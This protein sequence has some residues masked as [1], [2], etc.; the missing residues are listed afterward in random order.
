MPPGQ[1]HAFNTDVIA[2][3]EALSERVDLQGQSALVLGAGGVA[4]AATAALL[5]LGATVRVMNRTA[6]RA[7]ALAASFEGPVE[8]VTEP[9]SV[10][11]VVQCTSV[12]M[13]T[14]PD[15]KGCPVDPAI[16]PNNAV[17][18][19]PSTSPHSPHSERL[20]PKPEGSVLAVWK[21]SGGKPRPNAAS[22]LAKNPGLRPWPSWMILDSIW[23]RPL[24]CR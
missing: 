12:G 24:T 2:I 17:L 19:K 21:C 15:P 18:W 10:A 16:L 13:S 4:R 8:V 22:G 23:D 3:E 5:R 20:F 9:G 1:L 6:A 14:G 7:E 11:A